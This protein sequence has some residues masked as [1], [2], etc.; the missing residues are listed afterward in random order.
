M[1]S[2]PLFALLLHAGKWLK[3]MKQILHEIIFSHLWKWKK[4]KEEKRDIKLGT[5]SFVAIRNVD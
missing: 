4:I 5:I 1:L 2:A 3:K